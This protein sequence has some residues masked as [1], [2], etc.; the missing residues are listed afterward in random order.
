VLD[1]HDLIILY[2]SILMLSSLQSH[3]NLQKWKTVS[4]TV[5]HPPSEMW[6]QMTF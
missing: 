5:N 6:P 1:Y 2:N 4:L 3:H